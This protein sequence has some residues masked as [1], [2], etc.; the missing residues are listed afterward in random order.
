MIQVHVP[1]GVGV[2]VPLWAFSQWT[3]VLKR[4]T[5]SRY[6]FSRPCP[7]GM[8]IW[9]WSLFLATAGSGGF[10][11]HPNTLQE[12]P[13]SRYVMEPEDGLDSL[14]DCL[15]EKGIALVSAHRGGPI[16]GYPENAIETMANVMTQVPALLEV[17]VA[18]S[19]DGVLFLLHDDE[20]DRTT[21]G[22]GRAADWD[23]AELRELRLKDNDGAVTPFGVPTFD[24]ALEWA[25]DGAILQ[26]DLK[27]SSSLQ[28]VMEAVREKAMLDQVIWIAY[29]LERARVILSHAPGA[30]ISV[31]IENPDDW[32]VFLQSGIDGDSIMAWTGIRA[33]NAALYE[34]LETERIPIIFGTLGGKKSLD[35]QYAADGDLSEYLDLVS[36]GVDVI[37]TDRPF[38]AFGALG[39]Q[40]VLGCGISTGAAA[41]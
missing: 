13:S 17:D 3:M 27:P 15:Q 23:W 37:A 25:R 21:T 2:R 16:P 19:R 30:L 10:G 33:P 36:M 22:A 40:Q 11:E 1:R 6:G 18:Q 24:K 34:L 8:A 4:E 20:L 29:S 28:R 7:R 14:F 9:V 35:S 5:D 31:T 26:L 38:A 39:E 12:T 32:E 41:R